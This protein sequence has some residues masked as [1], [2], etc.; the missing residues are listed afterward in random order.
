MEDYLTDIIKI[1]LQEDIKNGDITTKA[2]IKSGAKATGNFLVKETGVIAGLKVAE[3]VFKIAD[4]ALKLKV[5]K[6][7]GTRVKKDDIAAVVTGD[8]AS[9][10]F[11]ERTALNFV[12]RMSGVATKTSHFVD[13]IKHTRTKIL[14]TRKTAP[15]LRLLDKEAVR[16]GGGINHRVGLF[17][18]FLIKDN[19]IAIAGSI[20]KAVNSCKK[21]MKEKKITNKIEVEA[22]N[23][24]EVKVAAE[25]SVDIIMLDNFKLGD[26][27]KAVELIK[28]RAAVEASGNVVLE[29]VKRI[30]ETGVDFISVGALTHSV[31]ALDISLDVIV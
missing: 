14:D 2:I 3:Q 12:Q 28:G 6:K 5:L 27:K 19:H 30:A 4:P 23:L 1:A 18:M 29:N 24:K 31:K 9:I 17:D 20:S 11:A 7:D 13:T 21:Y 8:A 25:C 26:L 22:K 10:L 16:M 15:G